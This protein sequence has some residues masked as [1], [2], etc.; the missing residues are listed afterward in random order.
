MFLKMPTAILTNAGTFLKMPTLSAHD[1][2][3]MFGAGHR[4]AFRHVLG[5]LRADL[6]EPHAGQ[7]VHEGAEVRG[8]VG[9]RNAR[10][11][12]RQPQHGE[13]EGELVGPVVPDIR[14]VEVRE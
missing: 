5:L 4:D 13:F 1:F 14:T 3:H 10:Q 12:L 9:L 11:G 6:L 7:G 2:S 8:T